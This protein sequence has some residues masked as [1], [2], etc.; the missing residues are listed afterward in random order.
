VFDAGSTGTRVHVITY[1]VGQDSDFP[2]ITQLAS[3]KVE[4]GLSAFASAP[5]EAAASIAPLIEFAE[6]RVAPADRART[7]LLLYGTAGMRLLSK[8]EQR[9]VYAS[10]RS[11]CAS[12]LF[13]VQLTS[14]STLS[15]EDEG[16][17]G[18]LALMWL[19]STATAPAGGGRR[20]DDSD[21]DSAAG[22][23]DLGGG[24]T[25]IAFPLTDASAS[26]L[27]TRSAME[28]GEGEDHAL[29]DGASLERAVHLGGANVPVFSRS[30]LGFGNRAALRRV[31]EI[32]LSRREPRRG[33]A[34]EHPCF[35]E[36]YNYT[37]RSA[38]FVGTAN[39]TAC[40]QLIGCLFDCTQPACQP[41]RGSAAERSQPCEHPEHFAR[42]A[43]PPKGLRFFGL[44]A[45]FYI[46]NY[47]TFKKKMGKMPTP[48]IRELRSATAA[49]CALPWTAVRLATRDPFTPEHKLPQRCFDAHYMLGLLVRG[50]GF[51]EESH[52]ITFL[53]KVGMGQPEW[54]YGAVLHFLHN[55]HT[56]RWPLWIYAAAACAALGFALVVGHF[57]RRRARQSRYATARRWPRE[58]P[59]PGG[60]APGGLVTHFSR[61]SSSAR[62]K[63][64]GTNSDASDGEDG[65][66]LQLSE[67]KGGFSFGRE[68]SDDDRAY[69]AD[70]PAAPRLGVAL[71]GGGACAS[72]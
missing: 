6:R 14:F 67:S 2:P 15:G 45:M 8:P 60:Y 24:S 34:L 63:T 11:R 72:V 31:E 69:G 39:S 13:D 7:P 19:H 10:V 65:A 9:R 57:F 50:F 54:P 41:I 33:E 58:T 25:Q 32:L 20:R 64:S 23:L 49:V 66:E 68:A 26:Q 5:E 70:E 44:S 71:G 55:R 53:E 48:S 4:P 46:T 35:H 3:T 51:D 37:S 17:F 61:P 62:L 12:T 47:L 22:I 29:E 16:F 1:S 40:G 28:A 21:G 43:S 52:Q 30:H 59:C 42:G 27:A 38:L 56:A 18:L 36:G